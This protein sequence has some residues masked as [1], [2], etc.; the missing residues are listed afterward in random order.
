MSSLLP[1]AF[2]P[3][4]GRSPSLGLQPLRDPGRC[5]RPPGTDRVPIFF[6]GVIDGDGCK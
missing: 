2:T 4:D 3:A 1:R 5:F 6:H